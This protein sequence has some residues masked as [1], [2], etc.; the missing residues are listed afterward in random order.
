[1]D[2][3]P[4]SIVE[5]AKDEEPTTGGP[6]PMSDGTIDYGVLSGRGKV[7]YLSLVY[8]EGDV[9]KRMPGPIEV[10]DVLFQPMHRK[11]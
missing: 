3:S 9:P 5:V 6:C 11:Q 2:R 8:G 4:S 10:Q 7:R 1:M